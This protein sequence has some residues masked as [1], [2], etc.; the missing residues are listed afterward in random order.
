MAEASSTKSFLNW[1]YST[2]FEDIPRDVRLM[3]VLALYDVIGCNLAC[4]LLPTAHRMVDF[5]NQTGGSPDCTMMGFPMRTSLV[6]AAM[7]NGT[8][9]HGDE[10]DAHD[11]DGRGTHI[12]G[13]DDRLGFGLR[14]VGESERTGGPA[15]SHPGI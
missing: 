9:G 10:M 5:V 2:G 1:M 13:R 3:A 7:V 12:A 11:G 14:P 15:G 4:S 6:N 8:L